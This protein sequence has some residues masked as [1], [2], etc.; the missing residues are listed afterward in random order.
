[1]RIET[2]ERVGFGGGTVWALACERVT[3]HLCLR[4][5]AGRHRRCPD[6][7]LLCRVGREF[8]RRGIAVLACGSLQLHEA[9]ECVTTAAPI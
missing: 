9:I 7:V 3:A 8:S 5:L 2:T 4:V 1:M 6:K